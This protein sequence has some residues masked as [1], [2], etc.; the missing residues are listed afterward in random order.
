LD[1]AVCI[2]NIGPRQRRLRRNLGIA[3]LAAG[4]AWVIAMWALEYPPY[5]R[6][7]G[8]VFFQGGFSG[9]FQ[10]RGKT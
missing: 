1:D 9:I 2:V 4:V 5:T 10:A 6:L 3:G 7:A 8:F